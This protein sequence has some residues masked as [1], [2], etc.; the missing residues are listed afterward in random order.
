MKN[1]EIQ[2]EIEKG[3][4]LKFVFLN[5]IPEVTQKRLNQIHPC[6]RFVINIVG[7]TFIWR[8]RLIETGATFVWQYGVSILHSHQNGHFNLYSQN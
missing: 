4:S 1:W 3:I 5:I 2:G 7:V 8:D 6:K